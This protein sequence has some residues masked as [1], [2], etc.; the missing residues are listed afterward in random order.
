[1]NTVGPDAVSYSKN[2]NFSFSNT[3]RNEKINLDDY[4]SATFIIDV[5]GTIYQGSAA[6][7]S[8]AS[9]IIIGGINQFV[10][11]KVS[12]PVANFYLSEQQL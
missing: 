11:E 4:S 7:E 1:M 3:L 5:N 10:N 2:L 8:S 12:R 9:I 6:N